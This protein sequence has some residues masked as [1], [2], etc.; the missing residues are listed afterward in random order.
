V[1][2]SAIVVLA[3][4]ACGD[5]S[6]GEVLQGG[7]DSIDD[8]GPMAFM[9]PLASLD[10]DQAEE[11]LLGNGPFAFHWT[12]PQLGRL[13]NHDSCVACHANNG[14][15]LSQI[16]PEDLLG[17][18]ALIR[19]SMDSGTPP[20][21]NGP[22]PVPDL[23]TQLQDHATFGLP[24]VIVHLTWV[25]TS[26]AYDD[27]EVVALR[28]PHLDVR[29][30]GGEPMPT[31]MLMSYRQ[32]P[33]LIGLGFLQ[34][35]SD[36]TLL[37]MEDP[38]DVDNDGISGH[39]NRAW[40]NASQSTK[41]GRFGHKASVPRLVEQVAGAFAN[42]MGLSNMLFLDADGTRDVTDLQLEQV[43][44]HVETLAVPIAGPRDAQAQRG[45][46]LF[47]LFQCSACHVPT[48][49][50]GDSPIRQLA[51]QTIHPYTDLL[52]HDMGDLLADGRPDFLADGT[53]WRT[54]PLWGIGL[55]QVVN[56]QATFLHDG[57]ARTFAEAILW[58][59]GEAEAAREAFRTAERRD[60]DALAAFLSTL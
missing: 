59:G 39:V 51:N 3:L 49:V 52:V 12:P 8:R 38:G 58:H 18:Q 13:F 6:P 31:G 11:H 37:S 45:R 14:R 57:R 48:L 2:A 35:V 1:R 33:P 9:H 17:S 26:V 19:V 60:R 46:Q 50:T 32:A 40:D 55:A 22:V 36:D 21:P 7:S 54:P 43:G 41:I 56:P 28:S 15:G 42:D 23:G 27:G 24:E 4:A 20:V 25:E 16:G 30:A 44:F 53:E 10:Q 47:D 5:D 29:R 34:A